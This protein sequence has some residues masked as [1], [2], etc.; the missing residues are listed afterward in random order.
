[1]IAWTRQAVD[2]ANMMLTLALRNDPDRVFER[3]TRLF[4]RDELGEA[5]PADV[6][7]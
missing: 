2:L 5:F 7:L 6:G 1:V 4:T 3:A